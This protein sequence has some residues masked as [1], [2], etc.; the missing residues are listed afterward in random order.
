MVL[1][2]AFSESAL[3]APADILNE[4]QLEPATDFPLPST[5]EFWNSYCEPMDTWYNEARGLS[6]V[7]CTCT[8]P[9]YETSIRDS[10]DQELNLLLAAVVRRLRRDASGSPISEVQYPSLLAA[11]AAMAAEDY[12][13]GKRMIRCPVC[14]L[15]WMSSAY[16]VSTALKNAP[17]GHENGA[18]GGSIMRETVYKRVQVV[19]DSKW[20]V[21]AVRGE[22]EE[23]K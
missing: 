2:N 9:S 3:F 8:D 10:G 22:R 15:Y 4:F 14:R 7:L 18:N 6:I 5:A 12:L 20:Y 17:G 11:L 21:D 16:Q 19:G 23:E 13:A 1:P